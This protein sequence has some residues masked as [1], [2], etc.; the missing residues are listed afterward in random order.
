MEIIDKDDI[1]IELTAEDNGLNQ[2]MDEF[3]VELNKRYQ[4]RI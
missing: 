1:K 4:T 2:E 3:H